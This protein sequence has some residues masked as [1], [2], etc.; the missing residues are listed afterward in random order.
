MRKLVLFNIR[1][2]SRVPDIGEFTLYISSIGEF[3]LYI[4][5]I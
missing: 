2:L 4:S 5:S 1:K 3:T